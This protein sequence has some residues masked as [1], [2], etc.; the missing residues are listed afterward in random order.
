M[1]KLEFLELIH[2]QKWRNKRYFKLDEAVIYV[3]TYFSSLD[4][5]AEW[6]PVLLGLHWEHNI[7]GGMFTVALTLQIEL[8]ESWYDWDEGCNGRVDSLWSWVANVKH[9]RHI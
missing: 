9:F 7:L 4:D 6:Y 8:E 5:L 1:R 2:A 3:E